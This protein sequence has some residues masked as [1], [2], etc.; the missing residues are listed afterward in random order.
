MSTDSLLK[1]ST[2]FRHLMRR[3]LDRLSETKSMLSTS[4]IFLASCSG[5]RSCAGR[6]TL[7][8]YFTVRLACRYSR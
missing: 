6:L 1:S 7:R 3:P 4:L 8:R 2:T 5:T